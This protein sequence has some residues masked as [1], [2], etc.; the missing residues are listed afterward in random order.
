MEDGVHH[1][2]DVIHDL[3]CVAFLLPLGDLGVPLCFSEVTIVHLHDEDGHGAA[4]R[5]VEVAVD[6]RMGLLPIHW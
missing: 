2:A 1:A 4:S 5:M 3:L 6:L